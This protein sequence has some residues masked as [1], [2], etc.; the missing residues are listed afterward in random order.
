M[1]VS[2]LRGRPP[3]HEIDKLATRMWFTAVSFAS[4]LPAGRL[5]MHIRTEL[6]ERYEEE[7]MQ[8]GAWYAYRNGDRSP[9]KR[10]V[11]AVEL[12]YPGT[13]AWKLSPLWFAM[14]ST[15]IS[16]KQ[17]QDLLVALSPEAEASLS[18]CFHS[19]NSRQS[20]NI[21]ALIQ[22]SSEMSV[23]TA[24]ALFLLQR[25]PAS[26]WHKRQEFV[27]AIRR[28]LFTQ[29]QQPQ[30]IRHHWGELVALCTTHA[31]ELGDLHRGVLDFTAN[32]NSEG[33]WEIFARGFAP[34]VFFEEHPRV[35]DSDI[36]NQRNPL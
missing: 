36:R 31:P 4:G 29:W 32:G 20:L 22:T 7:Q 9:S 17:I 15:A 3:Q 25:A 35:A 33:F 19:I 5:E 28:W 18:S 26:R 21:P 16:A 12:Q 6:R 27:D 13:A 24:G 10:L 11:S 34:G 14:R 1:A 8:T 30:V 2:A 23:E